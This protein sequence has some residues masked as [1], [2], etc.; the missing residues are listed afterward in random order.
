MALVDQ[1]IVE[2]II[3]FSTPAADDVQNKF[4]W[5]YDG[6]GMPDST[7][8]GLMDSWAEDFYE[9]AAAYFKSSITSFISEYNKLAWDDTLKKWYISANIG[10]GSGSVTFTDVNPLL[11]YQIAAVPVGLTAKPKSRGRKW[12]GLWCEDAQDNSKFVS[13]VATILAS[14]LTEYISQHVLQTNHAVDPGVVS[15]KWESFLPFVTGLVRDV[16]FTRKS[17]T[18]GRGS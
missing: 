14:M 11:P 5:Q 8:I 9:L 2:Q 16:C 15:V 12:I 18:R 17:R 13:G 4:T 10:T 1:D 6:T 3:T 7:F